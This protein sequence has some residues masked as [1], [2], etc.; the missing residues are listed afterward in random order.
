MLKR[1]RPSV[2]RGPRFLRSLFFAICRGGRAFFKMHGG[3][4]EAAAA[5]R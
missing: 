1:T 5:A 3:L 2:D 4:D